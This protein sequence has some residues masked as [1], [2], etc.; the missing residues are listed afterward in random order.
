[1]VTATAMREQE[2]DNR[3]RPAMHRLMGNLREWV[4]VHPMRQD[5]V[6]PEYD[7]TWVSGLS[8]QGPEKVVFDA[9]SET[10]EL[11]AHAIPA[12]CCIVHRETL[13]KYVGADATEYMAMHGANAVSN[14]AARVRFEREHKDRL[15]R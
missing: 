2:R 14:Q 1:M 15:S 3:L 6:M 12:E 11:W 4:R 5:D 8:G 13:K 10:P 9:I 7:V